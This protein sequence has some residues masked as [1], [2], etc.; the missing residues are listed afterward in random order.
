[1]RLAHRCTGTPEHRDPVRE[2]PWNAE[3]R[4]ASAGVLLCVAGTRRPDLPGCA[5]SCAATAHRRHPPK[6]AQVAS[7]VIP[8]PLRSASS[9]GVAGARPQLPRALPVPPKAGRADRF[10]GERQ[11]GWTLEDGREMRMV[12][13]ELERHT[14]RSTDGHAEPSAARGPGCLGGDALVC[15]GRNLRSAPRAVLG[16]RAGNHAQRGELR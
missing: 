3:S 8:G 4:A 10:V 11:V 15:K 6:P 9:F 1:M 13:P 16:A 7:S 12:R 14:K 5:G 2:R